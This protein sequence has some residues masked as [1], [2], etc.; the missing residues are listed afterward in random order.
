MNEYTSKVICNTI[1]SSASHDNDNNIDN[2]RTD[3]DTDTNMVVL[4]KKYYIT[5]NAGRIAE[6]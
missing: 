1:I 6:V 4:G 3:L 5:R 2:Y